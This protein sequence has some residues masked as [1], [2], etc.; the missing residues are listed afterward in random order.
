M[1]YLSEISWRHSL[2]FVTLFPNNS[3]FLCLSVCQLATS[4]LKLD[5]FQY[6]LHFQMGYLFENFWGHS[7]DVCTLIQKNSQ[8]LVCL[9]V[10]QLA[11]FLTEIRQIWGY[12]QFCMRY[13]SEFFLRNP[14][15]VF[16][17]VPNLFKFLVCLSVCDLAYLL[18]KIKL[19]WG[20]LQF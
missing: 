4:L 13:L 15:N 14:F 5:K 17:L 20:Y 9:S 7:L 10:C 2:D 3:D 11:Y 18:T 6:H 8:F 16:A 19:I 12:L 1:R